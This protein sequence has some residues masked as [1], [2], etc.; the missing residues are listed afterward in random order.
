MVAVEMDGNYIDVESMKSRET[1]S[2]VKAY[3]T[4]WS[5]WKA[6][7]A[8]SPNWHVLDNEARIE[9]KQAI[10]ENECTLE[11][12]P[13]DIH[14]Q[15]VAER[16]IQTFKSHFISILAGLPDNFP[17]HQWDELLPQTVLTLNLLHPTN[18]APNISACAYFHGQFDYDWMPQARLRC[19]IQ[20]HIK[21]KRRTAWGEH[22]SDGWYLGTS[23]EHYHC[24]IIFV[25]ATKTK[26]I[27]DTVFFKHHYITQPTLIA[28][29][30]V[31]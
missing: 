12:T 9:L 23:R 28:E 19:A 26:R 7:S 15:N 2:F 1:G 31:A 8:V 3:Q 30:T 18:M 11:L 20:F 17:I 29:D 16:G 24:H 25:K 10:K 13:S 22:A 6:T 21:P 14:W 27:T 4:I 5:L